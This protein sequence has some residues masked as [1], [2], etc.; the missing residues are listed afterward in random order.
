MREFKEEERS[1]LISV[2]LMKEI[3]VYKITVSPSVCKW[4]VQ[5]CDSDLKQRVLSFICLFVSLFCC[6]PHFSRFFS[7][8][9]FCYPHFSIHIFLSSFSHPQLSGPRFTDTP[10]NVNVKLW[11]LL[12]YSEK[13]S[14]QEAYLPKTSISGQI[15]SE[16]LAQLCSD[17]SVQIRLNL[18]WV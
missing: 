12:G 7:L 8:L 15:I 11:D 5:P 17:D 9:L 16:I 6:H 1:V 18:T 2:T 10:F 14:I 3:T 4:R 13:G